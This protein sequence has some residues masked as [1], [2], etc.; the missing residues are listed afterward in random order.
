MSGEAPDLRLLEKSLPSKN[1][2]III[3]FNISWITWWVRTTESRDYQE[4]L[5][6]FLNACWEPNP[7]A[8]FAAGLLQKIKKN[9]TTLPQ[10]LRPGVESG[11]VVAA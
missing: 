3:Q 9:Q 1:K 5:G 8:D 4:I 10:V 11:F 6:W 7:A 2:F